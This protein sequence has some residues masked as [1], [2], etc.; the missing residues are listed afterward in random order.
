MRK[1]PGNI[2]ATLALV[3]AMAGS[4]FAAGLP[5]KNSVR[6]D[7]IAN[8]EVKNADLGANSVT[9]RA[10]RPES[11]GDG[12]VRAIDT[13]RG[14]LDDAV[15]DDGNFTEGDPV[16]GR[17][18]IRFYPTCSREG[19]NVS[20][21]LRFALDPGFFY[22]YASLHGDGGSSGSGSGPGG[23]G[24]AA[25]G[26]TSRASQTFEFMIMVDE[27]A[28]SAQRLGG[29][30]MLTVNGVEADCEVVVNVQG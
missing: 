22:R 16:I 9:R 10:F 18:G 30:V 5:G 15:A 21:S 4:A 29:Q 25:F 3:V 23:S 20:A 2:I 14:S 17:E 12:D 28:G 19:T 7:D 11:V 8:G 27:L 6:S 1:H 13:V 24:V 26:E